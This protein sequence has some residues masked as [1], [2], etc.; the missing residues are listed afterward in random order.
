M[1]HMD[2]MAPWEVLSHIVD[3]P[4]EFNAGASNKRS[5]YVDAALLAGVQSLPDGKH[6]RALNYILCHPGALLCF[7]GTD[8]VRPALLEAINLL[9]TKEARA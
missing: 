6:K 5:Q 4:T 7:G 3:H 8:V 9:R 1:K 2:T